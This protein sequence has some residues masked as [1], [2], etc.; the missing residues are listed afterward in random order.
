MQLPDGRPEGEGGRI[1]RRDRIGQSRQRSVQPRDRRSRSTS[2]TTLPNKLETL[3]TDPYGAGWIVKIKHRRRIVARRTDGLP[4]RIRSSVPEERTKTTAWAISFNTPDDQRAML[5][6]IGV[7]SLDELFAQIPPELRLKRELDIP[8][9][10]SEIEL[11]AHMAELAGKE[12]RGRA[13][14]LLSRRRQLRSFHAGGG[15]LRRLA[16]RVLHVVHAL[17]AR[18]QPGKSASRSSNIKR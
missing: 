2:I 14:G 17:S 4:R 10:L 16:R 1:V 15:R 3:S 5:E 8:P 9:A 12:R 13:E 18:S 11:T 7:A 6:A